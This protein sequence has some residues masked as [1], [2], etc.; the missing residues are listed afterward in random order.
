MI[1]SSI[2]GASMF[3][4][5]DLM[6]S[7]AFNVLIKI[8]GKFIDLRTQKPRIDSECSLEKEFTELI[9][10]NPWMILYLTI[11]HI[12]SCHSCVYDPLTWDPEEILWMDECVLIM[13]YKSLITRFLKYYLLDKTWNLQIW[14]SMALDI[15]RYWLKEWDVMKSLAKVLEI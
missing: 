13:I 5:S 3:W 15:Y 7:H 11:N 14:S 9:C 6:Y 1:W 10:T 2:L 12:N 8:L 4:I